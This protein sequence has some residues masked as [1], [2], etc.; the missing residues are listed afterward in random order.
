VCVLLGRVTPFHILGFF[1]A[2]SVKCIESICDY[3]CESW[4]TAVSTRVRRLASSPRIVLLREVWT[5]ARSIRIAV[6]LL[7][8]AAAAAC[9]GGDGNEPEVDAPPTPTTA[10][11]SSS[12]TADDEGSTTSVPTTT[13]N[14]T[15][16]EAVADALQELAGRFDEAV[17]GILADPRVAGDP[18]HRAVLDYLDLFVPGSEF[19]AGALDAW[20][21]EGAEGRFY[22]PGP[23]GRMSESTVIDVAVDGTDTAT[24]TMCSITSVEI[25]DAA[26]QPVSGEGGNTA[27]AAVAVL[28][29]AEWRLR[30]LSETSPEGCEPVGE[31]EPAP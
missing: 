14:Q 28:V 23:R 2:P 30:E 20:A 7:T 3:T 15:D 19:A 13:A 21:Q 6:G 24:F 16:E 17:A 8:L 9:S 12:T 31:V 11:E 5:M 27:A 26:G 22:R 25:V 10:V 29:G 18:D 1:A 4:G